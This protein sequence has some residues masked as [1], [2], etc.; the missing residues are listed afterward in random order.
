VLL[1]STIDYMDGLILGHLT[2][3]PINERSANLAVFIFHNSPTLRDR[4]YRRCLPLVVL[5]LA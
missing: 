2:P 4:P 5:P 3:S 1:L